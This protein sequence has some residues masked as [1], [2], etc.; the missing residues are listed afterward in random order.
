MR[1][2]DW[3]SLIALLLII[4]IASLGEFISA[5]GNPAI[6]IGNLWYF[7]PM[8]ILLVC[9]VLMGR[10]KG[11]H[12][13][14][15]KW[16]SWTSYC[17]SIFFLFCS[18]NSFMHF[19]N[20]QD[21]SKKETLINNTV[22]VISDISNMHQAYKEGVDKRRQDYQHGLRTAIETNN[23]TMLNEVAPLQSRWTPKDAKKYADDWAE[24]TMLPTYKAYKTSL[25]SISPIIDNSIIR[26]FNI[27]TAGGKFI[28]L[29]TLYNLHKGQLSEKYSTLNKIEESEGINH[30]LMYSNNENKWKDSHRI[31]ETKEFSFVGFLIFIILAFLASLTFLCIKDESIRKPKMRTNVQ[32]VY[33][34]GHR[35]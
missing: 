17:L 8:I 14:L 34:A 27:F 30:E 19:F 24:K 3:I 6:T 12:A 25:D 18:V 11:N 26:D 20:V 5:Q 15:F 29:Q 4:A 7:I 10:R 23:T 32:D 28:S 13:S 35:L 9:A 1:R 16:L 22:L 31:Y 21:S 33:A 2:K